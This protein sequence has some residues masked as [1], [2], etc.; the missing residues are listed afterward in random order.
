MDLLKKIQQKKAC[1][2]V[3]GLGY[4]GLPLAVELAK[5]GYSVTGIDLDAE[6]VAQIQQGHSY[7][8]DVPPDDI[9]MLVRQGRL[10]AVTDYEAI[11]RLDTVSICVPTPLTKTKD[12]DVSYIVTAVDG[13]EKYMHP[14]MLIILESTT[15]PGTTEELV[16]ARLDKL[17]YQVGVDYFICFSPERVD[18]GNAKYNTKNTPKVIGGATPQCLALGT[19]LYSSFLPSIVQV[20]SPRVAEMVKLL[21]NT[22]RSVNIGLVN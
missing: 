19:E 22:F 2:G 14:G 6:K 15:Y 18:P 1:V 13:L 11:T 20:S 16:K 3:I 5:A 17:G 7:I 12:P 10:T 9:A 4:V 8:M 21:E